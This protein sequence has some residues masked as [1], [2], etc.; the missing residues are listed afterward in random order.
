MFLFMTEVSY[1]IALFKGMV[2]RSYILS[3]TL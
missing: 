1:N 3:N 2:V